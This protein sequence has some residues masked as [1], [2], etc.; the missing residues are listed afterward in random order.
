MARHDALPVADPIGQSAQLAAQVE[1]LRNRVGA[2][3]G[4]GAAVER[5]RERSRVFHTAGEFDRPPAQMVAA[6]ARWLV[7]QRPGQTGEKPGPQL[8]VL[9]AE[10]SQALLEEWHEPIVVS[11]PRPDESPTVARCRGGKLARQADSAG[12][13]GSVKECPLGTGSVASSRLG[14]AE[15]EQEL[16]ACPFVLRFHEV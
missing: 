1:A 4:G 14:F 12:D 3:D 5:V 10:G 9:F 8:D 16:A 2:E 15:R 13:G 7:A 11:G 6:I